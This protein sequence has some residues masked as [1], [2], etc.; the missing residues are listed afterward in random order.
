MIDMAEAEKEAITMN[1]ATGTT[2][3]RT[4]NMRG[5]TI[6]KAR[7]NETVIVNVIALAVDLESMT[8]IV[9]EM[10]VTVIVIVRN[11]VN[12]T[13]ITMNE[14]DLVRGTRSIEIGIRGIIVGMTTEEHLQMNTVVLIVTIPQTTVMSTDTPVKPAADTT[15]KLKKTME[16]MRVVREKEK[17]VMILLTGSTDAEVVNTEKTVAATEEVL[18]CWVRWQKIEST[19][20]RGGERIAAAAV[21][22]TR[23]IASNG[24]TLR[25]K[26]SDD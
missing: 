4:I 12:D 21:D 16:G 9:R 23:E 7:E 18:G 2:T 10:N 20:L 8:E 14:I 3:E 1:Q 26:R 11:H 17:E 5:R 13:M 25:A 22:A 24:D 15:N 19:P 6:V